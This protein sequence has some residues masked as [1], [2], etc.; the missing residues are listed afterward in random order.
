MKVTM[1]SSK[2]PYDRPPEFRSSVIK[3]EHI[4]KAF[5]EKLRRLKYFIRSDITDRAS[6]PQIS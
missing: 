3:E 2:S 4:E 5:I 6:S 1:S